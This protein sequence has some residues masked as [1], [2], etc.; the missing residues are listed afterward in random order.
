M[1]LGVTLA[2]F[3]IVPA[4]KTYETYGNPFQLPPS[5]SHQLTLLRLPPLLP[6]LF[7]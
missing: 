6:P 2:M 5:L 1:F 7:F 4:Y 3:A